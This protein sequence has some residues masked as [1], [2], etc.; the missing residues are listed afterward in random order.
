MKC[1]LYK[2]RPLSAFLLLLILGCKSNSQEL[3][4]TVD[5]DINSNQ[6]SWKSNIH[7][8]MAEAKSRNE[9][10]FVYCYSPTCSHCQ[11]VS[12]FFDTAEI[13]VK[14]NSNFTS[15][16][17]NLLEETEIKFLEDH[18]LNLLNWPRLLFFDGDGNLVHEAG[19]EPNMASIID[20]AEGALK[21]L[22]R[23]ESYAKRFKA[24]ERSI[25]FLSKYASFTKVTMDTTKG[26]E[27]AEALF[28]IYPKDKLGSQESWDLTKACVSDIDNGFAQYWLGHINQAKSYESDAG[29]SGSEGN[30]F[31]GIIQSS[32]FGRN[33]QTYSYAKLSEIR[34]HVNAIG[35][36]SFADNLL[37][38]FEVKALIKENKL[39][40]AMAIGNKMIQA[41][42][43]NGSAYVYI[44]RVYTDNFSDN[45]YVIVGKKWLTEALPTISQDNVKAEYFYEMARLN[46]KSKEMAEAKKNAHAALEL[47]TKIEAKS[48]KFKDLVDSL[49]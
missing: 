42:K 30:T 15:Y 12:P 48:T 46:Q 5:K 36:G 38:E 37:W 7:E 40:Q 4:K 14:Y 13:A 49:N 16:R 19:A 45:S 43:G 41:F 31:R 21:P 17:L 26:I 10:L 32:L 1:T 44:T 23:A 39:P 28:N 20:A 11:A 29:A 8:A 33:G 47:A 2:F 34:G 3:N 9:L 35:A 24:G 25:E 18:N 22:E 6:V 27:V